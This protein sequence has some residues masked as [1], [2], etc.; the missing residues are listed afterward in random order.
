MR[1]KVELEIEITGDA[2]LEEVEECLQFELGYNGSCSG[3]N[4]FL[5]DKACDYSVEEF[6]LDEI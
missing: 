1:V 5:T 2:T 3:D 6:Y 4:P